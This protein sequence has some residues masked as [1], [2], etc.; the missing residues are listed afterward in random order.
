MS[1]S[2]KRYSQTSP[3]SENLRLFLRT[4]DLVLLLTYLLLN[5]KVKR[6]NL[7]NSHYVELGPGPAKLRAIKSMLFLKV[8]Y[9][10]KYDY[11]DSR[12]CLLLDI[13]ESGIPQPRELLGPHSVAS[14]HLYFSDHCLEHLPYD[15]IVKFFS[16]Y[17]GSFVFRFPNTR[18]MSGRLDFQSDDSHVTPFTDDQLQ[19]LNHLSKECTGIPISLLFWDRL[20]STPLHRSLLSRN[21]AETSREICIYRLV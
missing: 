2:V 16:E 15:Q 14:D 17:H 3:L 11:G 12:D 19:L 18:S 5:T 10:D 9:I 1:K 8:L 7:F 6:R 21:R 20:Y 13:A 4:L